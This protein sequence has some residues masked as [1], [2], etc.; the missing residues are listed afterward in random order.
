[1]KRISNV[2]LLLFLFPTNTQARISSMEE[3]KAFLDKYCIEIINSI[4]ESYNKQIE[5]LEINNWEEFHKNGKWIGGLAD[6][7]Q[8]LCK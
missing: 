2:I 6:L 8:K 5:A 1:M 7:Y 3:S 4:S